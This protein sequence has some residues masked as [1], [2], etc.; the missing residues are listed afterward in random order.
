MASFLTRIPRVLAPRRLAADFGDAAELLVDNRRLLLT[1]ALRDLRSRYAGAFAGSFRIVGHPLFQIV[2][3]VFIFGV[4]LQQCIGG[5][6]DLPG[7]HTAYILSGLVLSISQP[8]NASCTAVVAA[9]LRPRLCRVQR[10]NQ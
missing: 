9:R 6:H 10:L 2:L 8:L 4:V 3:F 1:L 5:T 7:D